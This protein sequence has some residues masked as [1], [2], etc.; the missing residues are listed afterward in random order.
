MRAAEEGLLEKLKEDSRIDF[1]L[2]GFDGDRT[3]DIRRKIQ[4]G[5]REENAYEKISDSVEETARILSEGIRRVRLERR[6]KENSAGCTTAGG[7]RPL[8]FTG[9][10]AGYSQ[11]IPC[12][13]M[14]LCW[15]S[16]SFATRAVRQGEI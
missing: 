5:I 14:I 12:R 4:P 7:S 2:F 3:I 15:L 10:T 16:E 6:R 11:G 1:R 8:P 9:R 13:E